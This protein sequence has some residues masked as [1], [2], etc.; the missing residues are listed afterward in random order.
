[1]TD[2]DRVPTPAEDGAFNRWLLEFW[3]Q[4][5]TPTDARARTQ[6]RWM[7]KLAWDAGRE[8]FRGYLVDD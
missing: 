7:M 8:W 6:E 4:A 1:M 3:K 2:A 5:H